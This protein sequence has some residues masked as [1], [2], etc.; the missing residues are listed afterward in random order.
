MLRSEET[1]TRALPTPLW[2]KND[3][4]DIFSVH[5]GPIP[6]VRL[7]NQTNTKNNSF[8]SSETCHREKVDQLKRK[9]DNDDD[10]DVDD[11][12]NGDETDS[13]R[14]QRRLVFDRNNRVNNSCSSKI[15]KYDEN[16]NYAAKE[17]ETEASERELWTIVSMYKRANKWKIIAKRL[18]LKKHEIEEIQIRVKQQRK[19]N[20]TECLY[21]C[22]VKHR[23]HSDKPLRVESVLETFKIPQETYNKKL[24]DIESIISSSLK[25]EMNMRKPLSELDL[26]RISELIWADWKPLSRILGLGEH[27]ISYIED[28]HEEEGA[29]E[30]AYQSLLLLNPMPVETLMKALIELGLNYFARKLAQIVPL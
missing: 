27:Q 19:Q 24:E 29:R 20:D 14:E 22:L 28:N 26:W 9:R 2:T 3:M 21:Q 12:V 11:E 13:H 7:V 1:V 10:K 8:W 5:V 30:C 6:R 4:D 25:S 15:F 18:G 17:E 16:E 23:Q